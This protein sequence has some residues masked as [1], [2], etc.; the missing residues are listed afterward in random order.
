MWDVGLHNVGPFQTWWSW[1]WYIVAC[2]WH[3][4]H[5]VFGPTLSLSSL[6]MRLQRHIESWEEG[7]DEDRRYKHSLTAS[8]ALTL[9]CQSM[10]NLIYIYTSRSLDHIIN[11]KAWPSPQ[12][13][14]ANMLLQL[15]ISMAPN[16]WAP[17]AVHHTYHWFIMKAGIGTEIHQ[18]QG[19]WSYYTDVGK[20]FLGGGLE[21][22]QG[23]FQYGFKDYN[24][25]SEY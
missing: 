10:T 21:L 23:L 4:T 12:S 20:S 2:V 25:G 7:S 17:H 5:Y 19:T 13:D 1:R 6:S 11:R 8:R 14:T 18:W 16:L 9:L 15:P 3:I 22:W 24:S